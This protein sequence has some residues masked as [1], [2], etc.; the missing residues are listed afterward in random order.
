MYYEIAH[1]LSPY[2][3]DVMLANARQLGFIIG[4][5]AEGFGAP[6]SEKEQTARNAR[7]IYNA[8]RAY[9]FPPAPPARSVVP[10]IATRED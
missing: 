1:H 8:T 7:I 6:R 5:K 9:P 4:A 3:L 10:G 2:Q